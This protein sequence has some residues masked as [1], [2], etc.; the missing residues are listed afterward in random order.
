MPKVKAIFRSIDPGS[1]PLHSVD[2]VAGSQ[3]TLSAL[4]HLISAVIL[5]KQVS[6]FENG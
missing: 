4:G 5:S 6:L 3:K 2:F 1:R